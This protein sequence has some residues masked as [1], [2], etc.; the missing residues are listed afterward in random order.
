[1]KTASLTKDLIYKE[2]GPA[3]SVLLDSEAGKEIR[4]V[5]KK[6][7]EMRKHKAPYP[8]VVEIF[9]G[10]IEFGVEGEKYDLKKG[11]LIT[12]GGKIF[13]D[14]Y[15]KEDSIVRLSLNKKDTVKRASEVVNR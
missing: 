5:F 4:I 8:I 6:G 2:N 13:H 7:Q 12:L 3:L 1:M 14:L 15:A 9:E 11:D 10:F